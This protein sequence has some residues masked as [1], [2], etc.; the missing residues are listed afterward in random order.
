MRP[1]HRPFI[2]CLSVCLILLATACG[3][4]D[5]DGEAPASPLS[6]VGAGNAEIPRGF[7]ENFPLPDEFEVEQATFTEGDAFTQAN[8]LVRGTSPMSVS[9]LTEFYLGRLREAGYDVQGEAP[10]AGAANAVLTFRNEAIENG[11]VQLRTAGETTNVLI[12]LP[13]RD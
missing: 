6:D 7:P 11:S 1:Y 8:Y 4:P 3:A 5:T 9:G 2:S 10:A 13:L 12:S